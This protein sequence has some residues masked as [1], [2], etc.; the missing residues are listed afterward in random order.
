VDGNDTIDFSA[1]LEAAVIDLNDGTVSKVGAETYIGIARGTIIENTI[2]TDYDDHIKLNEAA[3]NVAAGAGD[4]IIIGADAS[5]ISDGGDGFDTVVVEADSSEVSLSNFT[6][7]E[8]VYFDDKAINLSGESQTN[9]EIKSGTVYVSRDDESF[10]FEE[11]NVSKDGAV[12]SVQTATPDAGSE[13]L[14]PTSNDNAVTVTSSGDL[15]VRQIEDTDIV[16]SSNYAV[17]QTVHFSNSVDNVYTIDVT[18]ANSRI[19]IFD[20]EGNDTLVLDNFEGWF[21]EE[22]TIENGVITIELTDANGGSIDIYLH[23]STAF[24]LIENL[25]IRYSDDNIQ[26]FLITPVDQ[27]Y[28]L[29][30]YQNFEGLPQDFPIEDVNDL[31]PGRNIGVQDYLSVNPRVPVSYQTLAPAVALSVPWQAGDD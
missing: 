22:S 28:E 21:V 6:G 19:D 20:Y 18:T 17:D 13:L 29:G 26:Q 11:W 5:A 9:A 10:G 24:G 7:V 31:Q 23:N 15:Y 16:V 12:G 4:D 30:W 27:V 25:E 14:A 2:A 8:I 3:N 1:M